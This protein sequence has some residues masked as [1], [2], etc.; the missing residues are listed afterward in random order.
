MRSYEAN[1]GN[2]DLIN[3]G[4]TRDRG[5]VA[6]SAMDTRL[7]RMDID[8][9]SPTQLQRRTMQQG[10]VEQGNEFRRGAAYQDHCSVGI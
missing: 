9:R 7:V 4:D 8:V 1:R 5:L 2:I 3:N 10:R 6:A